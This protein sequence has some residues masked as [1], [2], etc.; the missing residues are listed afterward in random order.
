MGGAYARETKSININRIKKKEAFL[1]KIISC[2][3]SYDDLP[4]FIKMSTKS[5]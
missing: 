1:T 3:Q 2:V 5:N 4:I